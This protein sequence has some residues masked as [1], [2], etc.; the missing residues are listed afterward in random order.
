MSKQKETLKFSQYANNINFFVTTED[1]V[2][3][4]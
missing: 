2:V 4:I 1:S 3:E